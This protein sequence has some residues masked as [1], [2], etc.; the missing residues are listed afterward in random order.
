MTFPVYYIHTEIKR[1]AYKQFLLDKSKSHSKIH[2]QE[3]K[4]NNLSK[5]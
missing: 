3:E 5:S 2:K 1:L 4:I